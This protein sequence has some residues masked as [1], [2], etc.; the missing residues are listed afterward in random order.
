MSEGETSHFETFGDVIAEFAHVDD[1][2]VLE[3]MKTTPALETALLLKRPNNWWGTGLNPKVLF[4]I[5]K[6]EGIPVAYVPSAEIL[7]DLAAA[8]DRNARMAILLVRKQEII[9]QCKDIINDCDDPWI[10]NER[11]LVGKAVAAYEDGHLE[12]ATALAVSVGESLATWASTP[13]SKFFNSEEEKEAWEKSRKVNSKYKW[14]EL[15]LS[16]AENDISPHKIL[17]A[18]IPQFFKSWKPN[19]GQKP[20]KFLSRHVVAH[21]PTLEHFSPENAL[22]ALMLVTSILH[23][24]QEWSEEVRS[25]DYL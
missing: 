14:A 12:A 4:T 8:P 1:P 24:I 25:M 17:M 16:R 6:D 20:P 11:A 23:D 19:K 13:R 15:E 5:A 10:V 3:R 18:P 22:L 21:Q 9:N 7:I 2:D